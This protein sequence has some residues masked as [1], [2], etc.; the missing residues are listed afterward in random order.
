MHTNNKQVNKA[1]IKKADGLR[2]DAFLTQAILNREKENYDHEVISVDLN[3]IMD[4]TVA[5]IPLQKNDVLYVPSI[6]GLKENETVTIHGE[7]GNPSTYGT[8]E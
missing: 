8:R 4:G 3:G 2:G 7:V 1:L 5:D 6:Q